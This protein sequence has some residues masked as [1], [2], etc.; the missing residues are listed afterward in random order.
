MAAQLR[1]T[2]YL[3]QRELRLELGRRLRAARG[4]LEAKEIAARAEIS[5]QFVYLIENGL[6]TAKPATLA[7]ILHAIGSLKHERRGPQ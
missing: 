3:T 5:R 4:E 7:R 1:V 6:R 2:D